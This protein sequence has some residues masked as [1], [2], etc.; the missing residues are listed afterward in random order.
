MERK[1]TRNV[2]LYLFKSE[3]ALHKAMRMYNLE[4]DTCTDIWAHTFRVQIGEIQT[5][6]LYTSR[7]SYWQNYRPSKWWDIG[8]IAIWE[9][10]LEDLDCHKKTIRFVQDWPGLPTGQRLE[11]FKLVTEQ[12]EPDTKFYRGRWFE[13]R[14]EQRVDRMG[15]ARFLKEHADFKILGS[16]TDREVVEDLATLHSVEL[17]H[18]HMGAILDSFGATVTEI[19]RYLN[20]TRFPMMND[21]AA[22]RHFAGKFEILEQV[23]DWEAKLDDP[24]VLLSINDLNINPGEIVNWAMGWRD[25]HC[26]ACPHSTILSLVNAGIDLRALFAALDNPVLFLRDQWYAPEIKQAYVVQD[27]HSLDWYIVYMNP[28][29]ADERTVERMICL[30]DGHYQYDLP[31][32]KVMIKIPFNSSAERCY[33]EHD[34]KYRLA[35]WYADQLKGAKK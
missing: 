2:Y 16:E 21:L 11:L 22:G 12:A 33:D 24:T 3:A 17:S 32:R 23:P 13:D 10:E 8:A 14:F 28:S 5:Y 34:A 26:V 4:E 30:A 29:A 15:V 31:S 19:A 6:A 7:I 25:R 27:P 20:A 18:E 35:K 9:V 1:R